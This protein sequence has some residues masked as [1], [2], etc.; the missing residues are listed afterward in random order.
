MQAWRRRAALIQFGAQ[1]IHVEGLVGQQ[2]GEIEILNERRG[3]DAVVALA[4]QQHEAHQSAERIDQRHDLG[5]QATARAPDGLN[6]ADA[7][8]WCR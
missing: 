2:R 5:G 4:G 3:P 7:V 8:L 1:P 6:R